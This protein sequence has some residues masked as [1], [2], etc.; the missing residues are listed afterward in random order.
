MN[1]F[2]AIFNKNFAECMK[3]EEEKVSQTEDKLYNNSYSPNSFHEG[4]ANAF[5]Q[6][7]QGLINI[8]ENSVNLTQHLPDLC[9]NF[10]NTESNPDI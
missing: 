7:D 8:V 6:H 10:V 4:V 9:T 3:K 5:S 2:N 1:L